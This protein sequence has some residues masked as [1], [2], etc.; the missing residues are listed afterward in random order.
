M[1]CTLTAMEDLSSRDRFPVGLV[2]LRG[3]VVLLSC[4]YVRM[5]R[6]ANAATC[7]VVVF[8]VTGSGKSRIG[9]ALAKSLR[10]T[11]YDADDFHGQKN[12]AK[13]QR[14]IPLSDRDRWPWL[15]RLR[16]IIKHCL[17]EHRSMILACS[18]LKRRYRRHLRISDR[19]RFVYLKIKPTVVERRL[20]QRKGHFMNADL[21]QSQFA[22]LEEPADDAM[23]A[24]AAQKPRD[25]VNGLRRRL[26]AQGCRAG[27]EVS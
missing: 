6:C 2:R 1:E 9:A 16:R 23:V 21:L 5:T 8:G 22:T 10:W 12:R 24:D 13:L 17:T 14:G 11:F 26:I 3:Q 15:N 18:A 25:I 4:R 20:Q 27:M 19:V 7:I